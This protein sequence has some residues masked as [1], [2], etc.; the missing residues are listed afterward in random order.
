MHN[1]HFQKLPFSFAN[2]WQTNAA[3]NPIRELRNANDYF[4]PQH[5]IETVKRMPLFS[6]PTIWNAEN[7]E[8][9]NPSLPVYLKSLK[10]RLLESLFIKICMYFM[11]P[12]TPPPS[13]PQ[14]SAN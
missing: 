10:K 7:N 2:L 6:F 5:R 8:K 3:R 14:T 11:P 12:P 1:Y 13:L 4:I 9:F